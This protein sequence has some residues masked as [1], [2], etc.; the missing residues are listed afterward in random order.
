[1]H[2][3]RN[4][5]NSTSETIF[6]HFFIAHAHMNSHFPLSVK[7]LT[8]DL[9]SLDLLSYRMGNFGNCTMFLT[10][11]KGQFNFLLHMSRNSHNSTSGIESGPI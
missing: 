8:L 4:G 2:A 10:T 5:H 7:N 9:S 3:C 6:G 11:F 1:M